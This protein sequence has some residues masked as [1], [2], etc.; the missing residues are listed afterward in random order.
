MPTF[1]LLGSMIIASFRNRLFIN[2]TLNAQQLADQVVPP[3]HQSIL[4]TGPWSIMML[5]KFS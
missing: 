4:S 2:A 3:V 5:C 1:A